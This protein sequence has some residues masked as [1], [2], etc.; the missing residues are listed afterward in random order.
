MTVPDTCPGT[1]AVAATDEGP[2]ARLATFVSQLSFADIPSSVIEHVKLALVDL[3][4]CALYGTTL[5][6]TQLAH[7]YVRSEQAGPAATLWGTTL[8]TSATLAT[9]AN[10][11]AA[12]AAEIDDLHKAS[13]HHP[14]AAVV[15]AALAVAESLPRTVTG[16]ELLTAIVAGYE[17]CTRVGAALGQG[18]FTAGYHPQGTAG[19]FGAAAAAARLRDLGPGSTVHALGIAGTQASG[20]MAAQEGAMVKRMHA[21]LAGQTGVRAAALAA[22]GFTGI[23]DVFEA[24]FGGLLTTLGTPASDPARL[25]AG[26][27]TVWHSGEIEFKRHAACAA[28]H[29]SLDVLEDLIAKHKVAAPDVASVRVR[30]TTHAFLHCG[31]PYRPKGATAAQMSFQYCVAAMLIFGAVAVDQFADDLLAE[32][33]LLKLAA[34]VEVTPETRFDELG[35][36]GRHAVRVEVLTGTGVTLSGDRGRRRGGVDDPVPPTA[37]I[38]KYRRLAAHA[39]DDR[40]VAALLDLIVHLERGDDVRALTTLMAGRGTR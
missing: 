10:G 18:H 17:V 29:S 9:L 39:L 26:L 23:V 7:R 21:G 2:T 36:D 24:T 35:A 4:G 19:V 27:G 32:P 5:P 13:F 34:R 11:T 40:G 25:T 37:I 15:P 31:F 8:R 28:I 16:A 20:L 30:C 22:E 38:D 1:G 14:S 3:L 12:H 33:D 6:W